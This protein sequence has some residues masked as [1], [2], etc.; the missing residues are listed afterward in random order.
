MYVVTF[1]SFKGGVG[2]SMALVNTAYEL[3]ASGVSVLLVDFDLEAPGLETFVSRE[4]AQPGVVDYINEYLASSTAPDVDDFVSECTSSFELEGVPPAGKMWFMSAGSQSGLYRANLAK[5]DWHSLYEERDGFLLLEDLKEQ[6]RLRF[7]PDYVLID[8]RTGYTDESGICTRQL[9]DA[10][11][12]MFFLNEQ[13]LAGMRAVVSEIKSEVNRSG[14]E[15]F[16][17]AV[18]SNVP[19]IDDEDVVVQ[20]FVKR[21]R[22]DLEVSKVII[23]NHYQSLDLISQKVFTLTRPRTRLT[24][25]YRAIVDTIRKNNHEDRTGVLSFLNEVVRTRGRDRGAPKDSNSKIEKI[26]LNHNSDP[27]VLL[28]AAKAWMQCAKYSEAVGALSRAIELGVNTSEAHRLRAQAR[29]LTYKPEGV[30]HDIRRALEAD[31]VGMDAV[32]MALR[33]LEPRNYQ[34]VVNTI[35]AR[36]SRFDSDDKDV[37]IRE[38][39]THPTLVPMSV[40]LFESMN[41]GQPSASAI[42]NHILG[43]I[44]LQ[45]Y[46]EA[47]RLLGPRAALHEKS[48]PDLFNYAMAEWGNTHKAPRDLF[49]IVVE[50]IPSELERRSEANQHHCF[51]I[52][53]SVLSRMEEANGHFDRAATS[54]KF[55][56]RAIFSPWSYLFLEADRFRE[57]VG[58][59]RSL[60][61][62]SSTVPLFMQQQLSQEMLLL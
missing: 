33:M 16:V 45:R 52:A 23:V 42:N 46:E 48:L 61:H 3:A 56:P 47:L 37:L 38:L 34:V 22:E 53:Y 19:D 58:E 44:H 20:D 5:I 18:A 35:S 62:D 17:H 26:V 10:V 6:W 36:M 51:A 50:R 40:A 57:E 2:R 4:A 8:S 30:E 41:D 55:G 13:N 24:R 7:N 60:M 43:L 14:K 31:D 32:I 21:F 27:E 25:Q 15:I 12:A 11:V 28:A 49:A 29:A 9:P 54:S 1:Y 39:M 59:S